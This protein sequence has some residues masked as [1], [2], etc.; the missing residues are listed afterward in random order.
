[1]S[2]LGQ[3]G[4]PVLPERS[5]VFVSATE[6]LAAAQAA[7]SSPQPID[8]CVT[9]P[10]ET[11]REAGVFACAGRPVRIVEEPLLSAR[12][13]GED[14][15]GQTARRA[16]ALR[17]VY[18]LDTRCALVVWDTLSVWTA[19]L[20]GGADPVVLEENWL[21]HTAEQIERHLPFP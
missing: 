5:F 8:L 7:W 18:A 13:P 2:I 17:A 15:L 20:P 10:S 4:G 16:D 6:P 21:L 1:V 14:E 9:A 3:R 19:L 12:W 11:A